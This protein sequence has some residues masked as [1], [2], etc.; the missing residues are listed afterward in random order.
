MGQCRLT[1][2]H[3]VHSHF[4]CRCC[5]WSAEPPYPPGI[6]EVAWDEATQYSGFSL[7]IFCV[8]SPTHHPNQTQYWEAE[9]LSTQLS[10]FPLDVSETRDKLAKLHLPALQPLTNCSVSHSL[11]LSPGSAVP[12]EELSLYSHS[13]ATKGLWIGASHW[14]GCYP[15]LE[16]VV[17]YHW[18]SMNQQST[19]AKVESAGIWRYSPHH[20]VLYPKIIQ[21]YR[22][23]GSR[24]LECGIQNAQNMIEI[25]VPRIKKITAWIIKDILQMPTLMWIML[26]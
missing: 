6:H 18:G 8:L 15:C 12:R 26:K 19:F 3:S 21:K 25:T 9:L 7:I 23:I 14:L 11:P 2:K 22:W 10:P 4:W 20:C 13:E 5:Q 16:W 1:S 17:C 24:V